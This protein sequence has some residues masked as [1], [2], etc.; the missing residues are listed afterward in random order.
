MIRDILKHRGEK[1]KASESRHLLWLAR[2]EKE[3][4]ALFIRQSK[5]VMA[6]FNIWVA[7]CCLLWQFIPPP[8]PPG[9]LGPI[10]DVPLL[11]AVGEATE[12]PFINLV[13]V[14]MAVKSGFDNVYI[15]TTALYN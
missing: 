4:A 6:F 8:H 5:T 11:N 13:V 2:V 10:L 3:E 1:E 15:D 12:E 14:Y 7:M 9:L